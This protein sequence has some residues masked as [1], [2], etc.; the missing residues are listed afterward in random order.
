MKIV[1][2]FLFLLIVFSGL[3]QNTVLKFK[4]ING[5]DYPKLKGEVWFRNPNQI[6]TSNVQISENGKI[7]PLNLSNQ[8]KGDSISKNK[9]VIFLMVNFLRFVINDVH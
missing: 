4:N 1:K 8:R 7:V 5:N 3:S 6:N 2:L 9:T